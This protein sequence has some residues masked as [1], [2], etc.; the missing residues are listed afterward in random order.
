MRPGWGGQ[1]MTRDAA[2][3]VLNDHLGEQA[4]A[5]LYIEREPP[6]PADD[7]LGFVIDTVVVMELN[8]V[9]DK[10]PDGF[11]GTYR[12]GEGLSG[13]DLNDVP[14]DGFEVGAHG[15]VVRIDRRVVLEIWVHGLGPVPR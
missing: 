13:I 7:G 9:L 5:M 4:S 1:T 8:G 2:L 14:A 10:D 6:R 11:L 12:I 3:L 15:F